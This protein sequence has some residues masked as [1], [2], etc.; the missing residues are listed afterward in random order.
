MRANEDFLPSHV[1]E[2][3]LNELRDASN[4]LDYDATRE[5][6]NKLVGEYVPNTNIDDL[7][8]AQKKGTAVN[9]PTPTVVDFPQREA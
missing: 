4:C 3:A 2:P 7:L 1:L 9:S 8:W 6:L 5:I